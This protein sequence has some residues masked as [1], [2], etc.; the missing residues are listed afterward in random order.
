MA[1]AWTMAHTAAKGEGGAPSGPPP[2]AR[3]TPRTR[4]AAFL[5]T[6]SEPPPAMAIRV[7]ALRRGRQCPWLRARGC[8]SPAFAGNTRPTTIRKS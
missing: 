5:T 6:V 8:N 2:A 4:A 1:Y 7:D 3:P